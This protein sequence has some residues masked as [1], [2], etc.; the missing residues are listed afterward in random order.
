MN[1]TRCHHHHL[2]EINMQQ[3]MKALCAERTA[4]FARVGQLVLEAELPPPG[5]G[6]ET[7]LVSAAESAT[8]FE[9]HADGMVLDRH[10]GLTWSP[11]LND[12]KT[13]KNHDHALQL[14]RE[15]DLGGHKDWRA[16]TVQELLGL[17]DYGRSKPAIDTA[18]FP[19]TKSDWYWTSSPYAGAPAYAWFVYFDDG[20]SNGVH[21]GYDGAFVRAVRGPAARTGQ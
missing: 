17:V 4:F 8:R 21:R 7:H 16:P 10:T 9:Q 12:G 14:C 5:V 3:L 11:T 20:S 1:C 2:P 13:C 19:D 15:L 6:A 18:A